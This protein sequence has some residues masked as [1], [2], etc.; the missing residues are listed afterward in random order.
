LLVIVSSEYRLRGYGK[1]LMSMLS[2]VAKNKGC[3]RISLEVRNE[4]RAIL[5]YKKL[6]FSNV[7]YIPCYYQD[8]TDAIV[9]EKGL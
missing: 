9:M 1:Q 8:G 5:F 4:S 3:N 7:D 2:K 6:D